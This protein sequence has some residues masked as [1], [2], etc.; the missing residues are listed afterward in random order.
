MDKI[1]VVTSLYKAAPYVE[2]FYR[3]HRACLERMGVDFEFVFVS[4]AS[5]DDAEGIVRQIIS[6]SPRV[7]LIVL[8]RNFGQHAAMFAG[9]ADARGNY[10]YALDCD[11]E[12]APENI[13]ELYEM[14]RRDPDLDVAYGVLK[15]RTGG[16][17]RNSLGAAFYA[18]F[19]LL[20]DVK[21]PRDQA[22]Q[23]IM[24]RR[25][26]DALL[27]YTEVETLPAGLMALAG[28]KQ[29]PLLIDKSYKGTTSYP[30]IKRFGLAFNSIIA[31]SS[32]PLALI[33]LLGLALTAVSSAII[34]FVVIARLLHYDFQSGWVSV[35]ASIWCAGG[36]ILS[37][38]GVIGIYMTKI[39]NQ[40]KAR[41]LYIVKSIVSSEN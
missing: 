13:V 26:V 29:K 6:R 17:F 5:P 28:F 30:F 15:K 21:I 37:S 19:D 8:S 12:E 38:V 36:L 31:F 22:W 10:I 18:L 2:E 32:R 20:A 14:V 33:C 39:F 35:I 9:L 1:S 16:F 25:Y 23:R 4:D 41:P 24:T 11:L 7:R 40:V 3:R 27:K 34:L